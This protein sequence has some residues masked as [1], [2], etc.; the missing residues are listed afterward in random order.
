MAKKLDD[1]LEELK[2]EHISPQDLNKIIDE[3]VLIL[4]NKGGSKN[5]YSDQVIIKKIL[6]LLQKHIIS[7]VG[8]H[9]DE[10]RQLNEKV[11]NFEARV[12]QLEEDKQQ[13]LINI[14]ELVQEYTRLNGG[15][16]RTQGVRKQNS[17][18]HYWWGRLPSTL[19]PS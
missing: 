1:C 16:E 2:K 3:C 18:S 13:G 11:A 8:C 17:S 4:D 7:L 19:K 12:Q 5:G 15:D 9:Q 10:I 6:L 14:Q